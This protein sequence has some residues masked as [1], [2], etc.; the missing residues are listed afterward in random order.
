MTIQPQYK[1]AAIPFGTTWVNTAPQFPEINFKKIESFRCWLALNY[2]NDETITEKMAIFLHSFIPI[3]RD[4]GNSRFL[5]Q[6]YK[7][8]CVNC[9]GNFKTVIKQSLLII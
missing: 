3:T 8:H 7:M 4:V 2:F 9:M 6:N 1:E 5:Y